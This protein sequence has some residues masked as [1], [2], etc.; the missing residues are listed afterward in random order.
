[1]LLPQLRAASVVP[2]IHD[3]LCGLSRSCR[4]KG[5]PDC[6][7]SSV[8]TDASDLEEAVGSTTRGR[9]ALGFTSDYGPA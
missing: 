4:A 1:M 5:E 9:S 2:E 3:E 8:R 7:S 6:A